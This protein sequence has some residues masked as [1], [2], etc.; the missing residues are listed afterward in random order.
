MLAVILP[1]ILLS[2]FHHHHP[3][4]DTHCFNCSHHLPHSHLGGISGTDD[5]LVCQFLAVVWV[6]SSEDLPE[7]PEVIDDF[8]YSFSEPYCGA[9][10]FSSVPPRAPPFVFC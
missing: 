5:C 4:T 6:P 7:R 2:S 9:T 10:D 8:E 3:V 1:T